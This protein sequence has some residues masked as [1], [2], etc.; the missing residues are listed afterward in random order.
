MQCAALA[1]CPEVWTDKEG[2][3]VEGTGFLLHIVLLLF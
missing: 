1:D 2:L 3:G